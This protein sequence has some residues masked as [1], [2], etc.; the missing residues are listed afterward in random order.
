MICEKCSGK[1]GA[2]NT[3]DFGDHVA[4]QRVCKVCGAV[5]YT[6]EEFIDDDT[7][8]DLVAERRKQYEM[9]RSSK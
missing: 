8:H 6:L 9:R 2:F 5:F 1:L 7:G 3:T 4:R